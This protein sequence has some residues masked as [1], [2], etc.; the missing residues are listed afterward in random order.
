MHNKILDSFKGV[1]T[2]SGHLIVAT[3]NGIFHS[4][5]VV[6]CAIL[7]LLEGDNVLFMRTR[8][9]NILASCDICVDVGGGKFDHHQPGFSECRKNGI[10]YASAGLVWREYGIELVKKLGFKYFPTEKFSAKAVS[11]IIDINEIALVDSEDNGIDVSG[12]KHS[13]SYIPSFLPIWTESNYDEQFGK[14]LE[15]TAITLEECI[16]AAI[17]EEVSKNTI[18][19]LWKDDNM[20]FDN[21]LELPS[22]TISWLKKVVELNGFISSDPIIFVIFPYPDGGWAAQCVP[23]SLEDRYSQIVP[24]PK[25]WAGLTTDLPFTSGVAEATFCHNGRFFVKATTREAVIKLCKKAMEHDSFYTRLAE[26]LNS[27]E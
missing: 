6:A 11:D 16:K 3:H 4:D 26:E 20:F 2:N 15:V 8:N 13:F 19:E 23:P 21:I 18:V 7:Y 14:V 17:S 25:H 9:R 22:Q 5:E 27:D 24:F 12:K 1:P 10:K